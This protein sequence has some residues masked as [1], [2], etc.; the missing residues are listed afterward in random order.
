[1][2]EQKKSI[3]FVLPCLNEERTLGLV[4]EKINF[5]K[6]NDLSARD[7]EIVVSDNGS[8][9]K[10][11]EIAKAYGA[12]VC[13]ASLK[14]YG[15]ALDF[16]IKNAVNDIIIFADADNTYDFYESKILIDKLDEGFDFVYGSRMKGS[17][18]NGAMPLLHRYIGTPVLNSIINLLHSKNGVKISDCN[19]GFRCF[20]KEKYLKLKIKGTGMEF[21]SE[22]LVKI[23][24]NEL[25]VADV[26]ISLYPDI[27]DREPHLSTWRDGMR[28]LLQILIE[29][30]EF[31]H[32]T[33]LF[34]WLINATIITVCLFSNPLSIGPFSLFGVHTMMFASFGSI[35]GLLIW[36]I[37][38]HIYIN[39]KKPITLYS[40]FIDLIEDK[41]FFYSVFS[42]LISFVMFSYILYSWYT[43]E[44]KFLQLEKQTLFLATFASNSIV[45]ITQIIA[46]HLIKKN[47]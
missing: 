24:K 25:K 16:G 40:Y 35:F 14:G 29:S 8:K 43:F 7:V 30:P 26:P 20:L 44:F 36:S 38:L 45:F 12:R 46:S 17:I 42:F 41:L 9:D 37:G 28:H 13:H 1:M 15:S 18:K 39:P 47:S 32:N 22:M 2:N 27:R 11:V 33:G 23:L 6:S 21:A 4:L 3:S 19:S 5:L 10:S 34:T 31:F